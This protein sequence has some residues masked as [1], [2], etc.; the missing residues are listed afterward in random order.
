MDSRQAQT[1]VAEMRRDSATARSF[2]V[3]E[4]RQASGNA[5]RERVLA[6]NAARES[7]SADQWRR[8]IGQG[9]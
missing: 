3:I 2:S 7:A 5:A 4:A 8:A 6:R 9:R 1:K